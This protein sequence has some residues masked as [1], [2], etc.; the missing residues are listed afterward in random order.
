MKIYPLKNGNL[1]ETER[2]EIARL[3]IKAGYTVRLGKEKPA[4]KSTVVHFVEYWDGDKE[5]TSC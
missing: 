2:L 1:N 5:E 3:L 4:G